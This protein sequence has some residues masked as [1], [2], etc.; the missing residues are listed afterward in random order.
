M[1]LEDQSAE[2]EGRQDAAKGRLVT[3]E[4]KFCQQEMYTRLPEEGRQ[5]G[6]ERKKNI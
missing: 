3:K 1:S 4:S 5:H 2:A 6:D